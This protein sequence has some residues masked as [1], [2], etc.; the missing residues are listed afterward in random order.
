MLKSFKLRMSNSEDAL[1]QIKKH[2]NLYV[3]T[4]RQEH[5]WNMFNS[6]YSVI[7]DFVNKSSWF[8]N[9]DYSIPSGLVESF[10]IAS[11]L[12]HTIL[13]QNHWRD[14]WVVTQLENQLM[15]DSGGKR[16]ISTALTKQDPH[17]FSRVVFFNP[18]NIDVNTV[19][20]N[21]KLLTDNQELADQFEDAIAVDGKINI[22]IKFENDQPYVTCFDGLMLFADP[23]TSLNEI[24]N[25]AD[26]RQKFDR[27]KVF[28][29]SCA[30][31]KIIN[32]YNFWYETDTQ[33]DADYTLEIFKPMTFYVDDLIFWMDLNYSTFED[34]YGRFKLIQQ[35]SNSLSKLI[36]IR[37]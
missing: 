31:T 34:F 16:V 10:G 28:I 15:F 27:P 7:L 1:S 25:F 29:K 21:P 4:L 2:G 18:Y 11:N 13:H 19:L 14:P 22:G 30:Q 5:F 8:Q 32:K 17:S 35:H 3:G 20:D 12:A 33:S 24:K 26:W 36:S 37:H 6:N 23:M 9:P